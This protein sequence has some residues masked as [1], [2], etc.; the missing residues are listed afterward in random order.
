MEEVVF[1]DPQVKTFL[2]GVKFEK[3]DVR[4]I[5]YVEA[6]AERVLVAQGASLTYINGTFKVSSDAQ[7]RFVEIN[8]Y[9]R[10]AI[11]GTP[12]VVVL[13]EVLGREYLR[14]HLLGA[15]P[16]EKFLQFLNTSLA[17]EGGKPA[18][19]FSQMAILAFAVV[20]GAA[21]AIS[22]CVV[23]P[24]ALAASRRRLIYFI[25]GSVLGY[26]IWSSVLTFSGIPVVLDKNLAAALILLFGVL[27]FL[28]ARGPYW[29]VQT[30][31]HKA[32][33]GSDFLAGAFLPFISLP[34][35]LPFFG[36]A[37][38]LSM[39]IFADVVERFLTFF[40]FGVSH[41]LSISIIGAL[42]RKLHKYHVFTTPIL[43]AAAV[44][45][46]YTV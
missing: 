40:L 36:I 17:G 8:D 27:Y 15:L 11:I 3:I 24:L 28:G 20:L 22:P 35:F 9:I 41:I 7:I 16:P 32:A 33:G 21:S 14:G 5:R 29:K 44:V 39:A 10:I 13:E 6:Y 46:L 2:S 26:V 30:F 31:F 38:V 23:V 12:T 34:C 43:I 42:I 25:A 4:I 19:G 45:L 37:G 1:S 18:L